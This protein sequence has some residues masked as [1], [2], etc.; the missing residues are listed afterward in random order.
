MGKYPKHWKS[1]TDEMP[2]DGMWIVVRRPDDTYR[3][4]CVCDSDPIGVLEQTGWGHLVEGE[5]CKKKY[6]HWVEMPPI[7][8]IW[9]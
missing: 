9:E 7:P 6:T 5:R 2:L 1:F 3:T 8:E 4:V